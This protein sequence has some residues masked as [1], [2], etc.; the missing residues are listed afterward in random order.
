VIERDAEPIRE[1]LVGADN[2]E[3]NSSNLQ[4]YFTRELCKIFPELYNASS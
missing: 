3:D 2:S 4:I 1:E